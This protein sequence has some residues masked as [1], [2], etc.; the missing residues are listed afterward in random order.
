MLKKTSVR[1]RILD[2]ISNPRFLAPILIAAGVGTLT[3]L[4]AV[5]FIK[6]VIACKHLFFDQGS[7]ILS[8]LGPYYVIFV[9]AFGGL[10]VGPL[11]TFF[12]PE[13]RGHGVPEVLKAVAIRG[14]RMRPVVVVVKALASILSLGSG[15][16]VGREGPIVQIG[17]AF[18]SST[19]QLLKLS[20]ARIKNLVACG[21][22]AG[23]AAVFNAPIA[24]VMFASEVILKDFAVSALSTVV[25]AAVSASIISRIFL[26]ESPAFAVPSY[27]LQSSWEILIYLGLGVLSAVAAVTFI[28]FLQK[29]ET[30]WEGV[31]VP[32]WSK[33]ALGGLMIGVMGVYF[34]Q[35][36]SS[37]LS[38]VQDA[39]HGNLP[40]LLLVSLVLLKMIAT[41]ISIGAGSS[42]GVFAPT[43]F[44]GAVL[45]GSVGKIMPRF[46]AFPMES[47]GAYALV[48]M[49]CVFSAAAHAP[50]TAILIVFEMTNGYHLILPL[51]IAVVVATSVSQYIHRE[52]IYTV[53]LKETGIDIGF[54]E[55]VRVLGGLQV[56]DAMNT[57]FEIVQNDTP[58]TELIA[59]M[60]HQKGKAI[61]TVDKKGHLAGVIKYEEIQKYLLDGDLQMVL[62]EDITLNI[63]E[64][65]FADEYL[66]EATRRMS[67][68]HLTILPVVDS[69]NT[70]HIVGVLRSE[71]ILTVY[72]HQALHRADIRH[73]EEQEPNMNQDVVTESFVVA[74][75][76]LLKGK[77]IKDLGL[78][79]GARFSH[80]KRGTK[81]LLPQG[82]V[83][84]KAKDRVWVTLMSDKKKNFYQWLK[85]Q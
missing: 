68:D 10:L 5:G 81:Y 16:S 38:T 19:G 11:I 75:H 62:A 74:S 80:I 78:P 28:R 12:A 45:G 72:S 85:V 13:A 24:G 32:V 77:A 58:A 61:F 31:K 34:P 66:V 79:Q 35:I 84:L 3:G 42:G 2:F 71:D 59:K 30:F 57:E 46:C 33:P 36:F 49:A 1:K 73:K 50:V 83:V 14:G 6:L 15:F 70:N 48:G 47:S 53:K 23:I 51:M 20:E 63:R 44:I 27:H 82:D 17:A 25:V 26:G 60:S 55:E 4:I 76:S 52:S 41:A 7:Q 21:A 18:G 40:I 43:L 67:V 64:F 54:L 56:K 39:L 69:E 29:S 22:A 65:C 37:G 9:P 8:G